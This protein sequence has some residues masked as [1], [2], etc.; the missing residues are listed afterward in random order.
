MHNDALTPT[1]FVYLHQ[2][3][4]NKARYET[5]WAVLR[6]F[7]YADDLSLEPT[8]VRPEVDAADDEPAELTRAGIDFFGSIF[9]RF[10]ANPQQCHS[11]DAT[12]L[13]AAGLAR[14]F[15][16]VSSFFF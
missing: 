5:V 13:S 15:A 4:I 12:R 6:A 16:P 3:F 8:Y 2:L 10:I 11:T 1:G 7:G 9:D 14:L